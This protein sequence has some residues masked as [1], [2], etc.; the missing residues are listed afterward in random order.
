MKNR[1]ILILNPASGTGDHVDRVEELAAQHGFEVWETEGEGHAVKLAEKAADQ[2]K[3]IAACGGDGTVNEVI[4]GIYRAGA[5]EDI[6]FGVVPA[7]TGNNFAGNIG[8]NSI[9]HAFKVI[10]NGERRVIDIGRAVNGVHRPFINSCIGGL[11]ADASMDS[12][13]DSKARWGTIAYVISTLR[14]LESFESMYLHVDAKNNTWR[15]DAAIVMVGNGRRFPAQGRTQANM[16]DGLLE[17]TIIEDKPAI[18]LAGEAAVKNLFGGKTPNISQFKASSLKIEV[19]DQDIWFSLDGEPVKA[20]KLK[21]D[22]MPTSLEIAVGRL[23]RPDPEAN[24]IR[25]LGRRIAGGI[26]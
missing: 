25:R 8:I 22:T 10:Q 14:S 9:R 13:S 11:T 23:Y 6:T 17:V 12:G 4:R 7:G 18:N 16:E 20:E 19:F 21:I 26:V 5:L 15:G 24:L 2:A 3:F 1:K